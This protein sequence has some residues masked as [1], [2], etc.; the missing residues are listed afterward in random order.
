MSNLVDVAAI[1]SGDDSSDD[2]EDLNESSDHCMRGFIADTDE[3]D[4]GDEGD[5]E[6]EDDLTH[7]SLDA[8]KE[9]FKQQIEDADTQE[10]MEDLQARHATTTNRKRSRSTRSLSGSVSDDQSINETPP[11]YNE[12]G[13][14]N[15]PDDPAALVFNQHTLDPYGLPQ[16]IALQPPEFV[17][18]MVIH[19]FKWW[20]TRDG[21]DSPAAC[22]EFA[23]SRYPGQD[24][25][26][27]QAMYKFY[28]LQ[29]SSVT[30]A[31]ITAGYMDHA[32]EENH[33]I[34]WYIRQ[35]SE[36]ITFC[37]TV[38]NNAVSMFL[39]STRSVPSIPAVSMSNA[40]IEDFRRGLGLTNT[41]KGEKLVWE[42]FQRMQLRRDGDR[43]FKPVY[44]KD[45]HGNLI[46]I[47]AYEHYY[48]HDA[49]D[50]IEEIISSL[51]MF[52][53]VSSDWN[54]VEHNSRPIADR[55]KTLNNTHLP[56]LVKDPRQISFKNG[57]YSLVY[58]V[59]MF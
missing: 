38:I 24:L 16:E 23:E 25:C 42:Q 55:M 15:E 54:L 11:V 26:K 45:P 27:A 14:P 35:I 12:P 52:C 13:E 58:L 5:E 33:H 46:F 17:L 56:R 10:Y 8:D 22:Y 30:K 49:A 43:L 34:M 28:I 19:Y 59:D 20:S 48:L 7:Y 41:L 6:D 57:V 3:E 40:M 37:F 36:R 31:A 47:H 29:L 44:T 21:F 4:E 39:S 32:Q 50:S 1:A 18:K 2:K 51:P 53:P 9:R